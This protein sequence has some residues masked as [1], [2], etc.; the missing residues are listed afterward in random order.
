M[1]SV[2]IHHRCPSDMRCSICIRNPQPT[3]SHS[4]GF[5]HSKV[6]CVTNGLPTLPSHYILTRLMCYPWYTNT[7][8]T[9]LYLLI[10]LEYYWDQPGYFYVIVSESDFNHDP[11]KKSWNLISSTDT[12]YSY[13]IHHMPH[14]HFSELWSLLGPAQVCKYVCCTLNTATQGMQE[15]GSAKH[16]I[17]TIAQDGHYPGS[18]KWLRHIIIKTSS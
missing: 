14:V 6:S 10:V 18:M 11:A 4:L 15:P 1:Y 17:C 3:K 16:T 9:L 13:K 7:S 2:P 5:V 8:I 12:V